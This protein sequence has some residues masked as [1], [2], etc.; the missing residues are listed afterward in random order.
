MAERLTRQQRKAQTR[1]RLLDAAA[2]IFAE[3]GLA[4]ASL[5]EVA[6]Q[7]G[8]TKGAVYS[9]FASKTDL[10]IALLERRIASQSELLTSRFAGKDVETVSLELESSA[11]VPEADRAFLVLAVEFWLHAMRD[12]HARSLVAQEYEHARTVVA[13]QLD[14]AGYASSAAAA[15]LSSRE[16]AIVVEALGTGLALQAALDPEHVR[17]DLMATVIALLMGRGGGVNGS[18]PVGTATDA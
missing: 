4:A 5:D 3:R 15:R 18:E 13:R 10:V 16:M 7:A 17:A 11:K 6:A 2:T 9:N 8:Y 1:D 14:A 12:E